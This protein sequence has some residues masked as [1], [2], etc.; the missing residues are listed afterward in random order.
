MF[1]DGNMLIDANGD[2]VT[3]MAVHFEGV[4]AM[5]GTDFIF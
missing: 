5:A 1:A 3:D 4:T 2:G